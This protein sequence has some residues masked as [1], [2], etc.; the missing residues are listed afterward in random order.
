M[1]IKLC[2]FILIM[3]LHISLLAQSF[4]SIILPQYIQG[5]T[6]TNSNRIP[7]VYHIRITGLTAGASYRYYNQVVRSADAD[8]TNGAGNC[9]FAT[10]TGDFIRT[11]SPSLKKAGAYGTFTTDGTG[12]C[13]GWCITE[14]TGNE[15]FLPG[16]YIFMRIILNDG[17]I[18]TSPAMRLTTADSVRVIKL[19]P[20]FTDSTGTGL[21]CTSVAN[22]KDFIFIYDNKEG[23]NRPI[24]GSFIENDGTD[25]SISNNYAAFYA[26]KVNGIDGS[27]G[28][29]LPNVLPNGVRRVER[30]SLATGGVAVFASDDDGIWPSGVNTINPSGGTVEL[31]LAGTDVQ[32]AT[33]VQSSNINPLEFILFQNY[34]NPFNPSTVI[35]YQLKEVSLV[36]LKVF[37]ILGREA[38]TLV[39]EVKN[40]GYYTATF[41]GSRLS[42]G[43][44][45]IRM[46]AL[47]KKGMPI[48]QMKK[49]QLVK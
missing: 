33:R 25:N 17:G 43:I 27:F 47:T 1:K 6:G 39:D 5:N 20:A 48:I 16:T 2:V 29:I 41:D 19:D 40:A 28:A 31:V 34:P 13:E 12:T 8:T 4:T 21:R 15:R 22:P 49:M 7:F 10:A 46:I 30:R 14:P 3:V 45:F 18:G 23:T 38:T 9:I 44:Y 37:D 24:S 36:K 42:S 26:N 35:N 32:W 11:T